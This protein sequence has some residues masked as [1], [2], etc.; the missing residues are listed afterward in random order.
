MEVPGGIKSRILRKFGV[1]FSQSVIRDSLLYKIVTLAKKIRFYFLPEA[2]L[3][4]FQ[5]KRT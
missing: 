2:K 1:L 4:F 3:Q 5:R